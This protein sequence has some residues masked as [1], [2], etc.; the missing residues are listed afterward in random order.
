MGLDMNESQIRTYAKLMRELGLTGIEVN[1]QT[2]HLRL[3]MAPGAGLSMVSGSRKAE[4]MI[5]SLT[6]KG[7]AESLAMPEVLSEPMI[8]GGTDIAAANV[9]A[10]SKSG[11]TAIVTAPT[12]GVFYAAPQ[13]N[14]DPYV[15]VGDTVKKGTVLCIIETMKLMNEIT[16][17]HDGVIEEILVKN[18]QIVEYGTELFRIRETS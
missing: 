3:E 6:L 17:E 11:N 10:A 5:D 9:S 2:G 14:A 13:E 4:A 1:E 18:A 15:K 7:T 12:V 8:K 16:S